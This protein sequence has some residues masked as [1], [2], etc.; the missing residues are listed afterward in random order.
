MEIVG[1]KDVA[2]FVARARDNRLPSGGSGGSF[3]AFKAA[4]VFGL[5]AVGVKP[6][7]GLQDGGRLLESCDIS[8][9][10]RD[11]SCLV[12]SSFCSSGS[13]NGS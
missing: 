4:K 9:L 6:T 8:R 1:R 11:M 7:C 10:S 12:A 2:L 13:I 3:C 5:N